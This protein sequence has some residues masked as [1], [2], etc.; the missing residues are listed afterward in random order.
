MPQFHKGLHV[1]VVS[2]RCHSHVAIHMPIFD[3]KCKS[4]GHT[5]EAL[6]LRGKEPPCASCGA[7]EL[8]KLLSL[9]AIKSASTRDLSMRA[10]KRR[11]KVQ[12][13]DR[14]NDQRQYEESHDRHG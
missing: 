1:A 9:P 3:Y 13:T 8:E 4:C 10:A 11:D 5:F 6:V 14:M 7:I 2:R 12:G